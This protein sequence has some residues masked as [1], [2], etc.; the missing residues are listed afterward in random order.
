MRSA[1]CVMND[2]AD[3]KID[4]HVSRT[5]DRPLAA[6]RISKREALALAGV[7]SLLSFLLIL[8]LNRLTLEMS[9][10]ALF[11]A[12]SYPLTKR[13]FPLPQAYLGLAFSFGIPMTFAAA[14]DVVHPI[15]WALLAANL[16]W[17]IAYDTAYAMVD[18]PD[19]LKIGIKSS[20]IT[21]GRFDA[22]AVMVCHALFLA[23]MV[24]IGCY[25]HAGVAWYCGLG[26][27]AMLMALQYREIRTHEPAK[28]FRA[29]LAN[30]WVG[31]VVFLGIA[32]DC[33]QN[34]WRYAD[35]LGVRILSI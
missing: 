15:A 8:P 4:I 5:K 2:I 27:A 28:C 31:A 33:H 23:S 26:L 19:D 10:P 9:I 25:I 24:A 11:L 6:G 30:N 18:K 7:L 17:V 35:L 1:G 20:A 21:F 32:V 16:F 3:S 13:F 12:A 22:E 34:Y 14:R 29:F